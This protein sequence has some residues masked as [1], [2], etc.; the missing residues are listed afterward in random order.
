MNN[1][2]GLTFKIVVDDSG[3]P[4]S[5]TRAADSM[6]KVAAQATVGQKKYAE[7]A[8]ST[9]L[10]R[11]ETL[12]LNYTL[13]D[14]AASL[15]SGASPWTILL[16]QGGQVKD[17]FG[18]LGPLFSKVSA[19]LTPVRVAAGLGAAALGTVAYA[20]FEGSKQS[21]AFNKS[22]TLT[23]N[24]AGITAGQFEAMARDI[25]QSSR[26]TVGAGKD[27]L[28]ALVATGQVGPESIEAVSRAALTLSEISGRSAEDVA[29]D[30][31]S[32]SRGVAKWALE[33]NRQYNYL[34][35]EQYKYIQLLERQGRVEEAMR[36]NSELYDKAAKARRGELGYLG[37]ALQ[38]VTKLW[39]EFWNAATG[40]GKPDTLEQQLAGLDAQIKS[41]QPRS[42]S[43]SLNFRDTERLKELQAARENMKARIDLERLGAKAR[44]AV[45]ADEQK[46]IEGQ[47]KEHQGALLNLERTGLN[48]RQAQQ[49]FGRE[50]EALLDKR[51]FDSA[52]ITGVT[53]MQ[54]RIA[55]ERAALDA[56]QAAINGEIALEKRQPIEKGGEAAQKGRLLDLEIKTLGVRT[57]RLKLEDKISRGEFYTA[58]PEMVDTK[59]KFLQ[60]ERAQQAE[61]EKAIEQRNKR[62][63]DGI[64]DLANVNRS[65]SIALLQDERQ[66]AEAT[67]ALDED[68]IRQ[69]LELA[70]M[71]VS[72]RQLAEQALAEWR[73]LRE[74][75]LTEELKPEYQ[76]RLELFQDLQRYMR[77]AQEEFMQGFI[78]QGR[79][80]FTEW[81]TTGKF[82]T[83]QLV[84]F[85]QQEFAKI[86]YDKYLSGAVA[87]IGEY[88]LKA[89]TGFDTTGG[90]GFTTNTTGTSLPTAGGKA[91]GG[92][93]RAGT[94]TRVNERG[95]EL[96]TV[97][98]NDY[99]MMGN[100]D[101]KVT[102]AGNF[103][104][105]AGAPVNIYN[106][107][108]GTG[109]T[110]N[111]LMNGMAVAA[112]MAV[113]R[114]AEA[115]RHG[116]RAFQEG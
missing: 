61:T 97:R 80:A 8:K 92:T 60:F 79:S 13:S 46:K 40:L 2:D 67:I 15:A 101:G 4:A 43:G 5:A 87:N 86:V 26:S 91:A 88:L 21:E 104:Q 11:Q 14:V 111:E 58:P 65:A 64:N 9:A 54:R 69:R 84:N 109:V 32:M 68:T 23:G 48:L 96:L 93:V 31:A 106:T 47:S 34:T 7:L 62:A 6:G 78:D 49:E 115:R 33:R 12:A 85:I 50:R 20:M 16:Q 71:S 38:S 113:N 108:T 35:V 27:I 95:T 10:T 90:A 105:P 81:V 29:K 89:F 57:E 83:R 59:Q 77:Q 102:P 1:A 24:Y 51:A 76:R 75:Q 100:T 37:T 70:T 63:A 116:N 112:D 3:L 25:T 98:G 56:K 55:R 44:A 72:D 94:L 41:L 82:S 30:F 53:Y 66:R 18:G 45:A 39:G 17:Q 52:E 19:L 28:Q 73:V 22:I 110:R 107:F 114:V 103:G 42:S 74:R 99:L 36:V